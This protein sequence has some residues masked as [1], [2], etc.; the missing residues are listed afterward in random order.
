[1]EE[2]LEEVESNGKPHDPTA[3]EKITDE[4][5]PERCQGLNKPRTNIGGK[6][7]QDEGSPQCLFKRV[8]GSN[9]CPRHG[10]GAALA[11]AKKEE[12]RNYHLGKWSMRVNQFADNPE[13]KSLREEIGIVRMMIETVVGKCKDENDVI[14][15]S[16]KLQNLIQQAQK[17]V[18]SC[19]R[20]EER[21]GVLLDKQSI[22]V[23]CDSLVKIIAVHVEDPDALDTIAAQMV[24]VVAKIGGIENVNEH[25]PSV[26]GTN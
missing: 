8:K 26:A 10:G 3:W 13:I 21:T 25:A 24:D 23:V 17:L 20:L 4:A 15:Y 5:D 2:P 9:F 7:G 14:L 22:L 1:M 11:K 6:G 18:E 12:T 16:G 19:H